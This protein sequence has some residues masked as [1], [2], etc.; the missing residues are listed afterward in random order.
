MVLPGVHKSQLLL[1]ER[2]TLNLAEA[3]AILHVDLF[4]LDNLK[5][6]R[7]HFHA[8]SYFQIIELL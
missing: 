6:V 2:P 8:L 1:T 4:L 3:R 7:M 5:Q